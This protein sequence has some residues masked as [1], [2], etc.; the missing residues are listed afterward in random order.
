MPDIWIPGGPWA[1]YA[2]LRTSHT[3]SGGVTDAWD[4]SL[5]ATNYLAQI[6]AGAAIDTT[7]PFTEFTPTRLPQIV[8]GAGGANPVVYTLTG[9]DIITG[10][11]FA[12]TITAA[13]AG[14]Y[15][16]AS[17]MA[18]VT[19]LESDIDPLGTTDLQAGDTWVPAARRLFITVGGDVAGQLRE[20]KQD[21][22]LPWTA[23]DHGAHYEI[24]RISGT[25]ATGLKLGW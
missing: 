20:S 13:G 15:K 23:G 4:V 5:T 3:D 17:P 22:T 2:S 18:I 21:V 8:L 10:E 24:I 25:T 14:T 16:A 7:G 6:A 19:R 11:E 9:L 1:E 12:Q